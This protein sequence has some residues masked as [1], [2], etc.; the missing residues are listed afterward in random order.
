MVEP[1]L[2]PPQSGPRSPFS[3]WGK[4]AY[5]LLVTI[6]GAAGYVYVSTVYERLSNHTMQNDFALFYA[7]SV[8]T[9][10]GKSQPLNI[11]DHL[12]FTDYVNKFYPP[13]NPPIVYYMLYPPYFLT[14]L[15]PLHLIP[16][17]DAWLVWVLASSVLI[18]TSL[19]LLT[20][21]RFSVAGAALIILATMMTSAAWYNFVGGQTAAILLFGLTLTWML[22]KDEKY[23]TA[24]LATGIVLMKLQFAP[25]LLLVGLL[26]GKFRY[27]IGLAVAAVMLLGLGVLSVGIDNTLAYPNSLHESEN[28]EVHEKYVLGSNFRAAIGMLPFVTPDNATPIAIAAF[29]LAAFGVL[30]LW[31]KIYPRLQEASKPAF[32]ICASVTTLLIVM[33][34]IHANMYDYLSVAIAFIWLWHWTSTDSFFDFHKPIQLAL[35]GSILVFPVLTQ[36]N[37]ARQLLDN[38]GW[39]TGFIGGMAVLVLTLLAIRQ[40]TS[41][42]KTT[43]SP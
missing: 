36:I 13:H 25:L 17:H 14:L 15:E 8:M 29:A 21:H 41:P 26:R 24:G 38:H 31:L 39:S 10:A 20:R 3:T 27:A 4:L 6:C 22:L 32:E 37:V 16:L 11:Y 5:A 33:F 34:S 12:V 30:V 35:R 42:N 23:I 19:L 28:Y 7:A 2:T 9:A 1:E 43:E 40:A 18:V